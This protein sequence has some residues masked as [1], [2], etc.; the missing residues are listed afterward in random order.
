MCDWVA[1]TPKSTMHINVQT[2]CALGQVASHQADSGFVRR[3]TFQPAKCCKM[4]ECPQWRAALQHDRC[5]A[6]GSDGPFVSIESKGGVRTFAA[7]RSKVC[8]A[9]QSELSLRLRQWPLTE[10]DHW[11]MLPR[12]ISLGQ[13]Q[14]AP[15]VS[16]GTR[17]TLRWR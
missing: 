6:N 15:C 1:P 9:G 7:L 2:F 14:K 4:H 10:L 12:G 5:G 8:N 3:L 11:A 16:G 17:Q 13:T